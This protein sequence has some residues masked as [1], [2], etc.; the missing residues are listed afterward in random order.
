MFLYFCCFLH[1]VMTPLLCQAAGSRPPPPNKLPCGASWPAMIPNF[2][3]VYDLCVR[4][5]SR[6]GSLQALLVPLQGVVWDLCNGKCRVPGQDVEYPTTPT[7]TP[8]PHHT[9][10]E[11][12]WGRIWRRYKLLLAS[13]SLVSPPVSWFISASRPNPG[14]SAGATLLHLFSPSKRCLCIAPLHPLVTL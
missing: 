1:C 10:T 7:P 14:K 2:W 8:R 13:G 3:L 5:Q 11:A 6:A 12:R 4:V 9:G